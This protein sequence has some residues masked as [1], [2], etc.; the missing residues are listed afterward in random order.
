[1]GGHSSYF[2]NAARKALWSDMTRIL[3]LD[4]M[5]FLLPFIVYGG[6]R[7]LVKGARGRHE[8]MSDAPIFGLLALG[9]LFGAGRIILPGLP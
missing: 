8:L 7:W 1:M 3:L 4:V 9:I 2:E 5:L 6:W